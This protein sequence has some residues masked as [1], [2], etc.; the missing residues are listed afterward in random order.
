MFFGGY[1]LARAGETPSAADAD[2]FL[3]ESVGMKE[4]LPDGWGQVVS[5]AACH[6]QQVATPGEALT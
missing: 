3:D 1:P 5:A 6:R 2:H 4:G